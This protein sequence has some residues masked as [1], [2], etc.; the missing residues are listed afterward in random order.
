MYV[1]Q[2][3]AP[4]RKKIESMSA[5]AGEFWIGLEKIAKKPWGYFGCLPLVN[6]ESFKNI[7]SNSIDK[8]GIEFI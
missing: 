3:V 8:P 7:T 5:I 1:H 4:S 6:I 2:R